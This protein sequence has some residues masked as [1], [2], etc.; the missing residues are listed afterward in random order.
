[1]YI[2]FKASD[3]E[4]IFV[5][6]HKFA[7]QY[8]IL[9]ILRMVLQY[10]DSCYAMP[11]RFFVTVVPALGDHRRER[12]PAVCGHIINV[13]THVNV[14]LPPISG[15]PPNADADSHLL[16]VS[17]CY[18]GQ[19]K[20][21]PRFRWSFQPKIAGAHPNLRLIIRSNFCAIVQRAI[22]YVIETNEPRACG[23]LV[24]FVLRH[25]V[26][27]VTY[28]VFQSAMSKK[29]TIFSSSLDQRIEMLRRLDETHRVEQGACWWAKRK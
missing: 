27:K 10:E 29:G 14:T 9:V 26:V 21:M 2:F 1:M 20:Q 6:I 13:P 3:P 25:H 17:T 23:K 22:L 19:C 11:I 5:M 24:T 7:F 8:R 12:P 4:S 18:N 15:H 28:F 16:V